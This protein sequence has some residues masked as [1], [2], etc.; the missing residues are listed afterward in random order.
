M[1]SAVLLLG[2]IY[3]DEALQN[4]NDPCEISSPELITNIAQLL[5]IPRVDL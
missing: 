4:D 3:F 2:N 5:K 1:I